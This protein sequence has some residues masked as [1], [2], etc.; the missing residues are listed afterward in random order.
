M[1]RGVELEVAG[2]EPGGV[3]RLGTA[4]AEEIAGVLGSVET[5]A[6]EEHGRSREAH[7]KLGSC[8]GAGESREEQGGRT[9]IRNM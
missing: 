5:G 4:E 3:R 7:G 9:G 2:G 1:I 6:W 8:E